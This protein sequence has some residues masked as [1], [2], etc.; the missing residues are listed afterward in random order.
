MAETI[1]ARTTQEQSGDY[2]V[3]ATATVGG[4]QPVKGLAIHQD[5][6]ERVG[7][8][9]YATVEL[10]EDGPEPLV[11]EPD[12]ATSA[13]VRMQ[14]ASGPAVRHVYVSPEFLSQF[15]ETFEFDGEET[16]LDAVPSL[17]ISGL[18]ASDEESY[19]QD[20]DARSSAEEA[21]DALFGDESDDSEESEEADAEES[22]EDESDE[23]KVEIAD[24]E[25]GI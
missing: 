23:E 20:K 24:D 25:L 14:S 8:P 21:A 9:E 18:E 10:S 5:V 2:R 15:D 16:D 19:E 6:I 11:L 1:E 12:K 4:E 13:T 22:E 3:Y 7:S 17:A